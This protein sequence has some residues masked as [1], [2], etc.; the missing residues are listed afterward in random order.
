MRGWMVW[1]YYLVRI[2]ARLVVWA[3]YLVRI[4]A[5]L[6]GVGVILGED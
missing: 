2:D 4:D 5:R 3:C 1:V 6:G